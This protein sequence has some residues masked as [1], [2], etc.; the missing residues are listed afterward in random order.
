MLTAGAAVTNGCGCARNG[1][2]TQVR[3]RGPSRR[4]HTHPRLS[5]TS[6]QPS[7]TLCHRP[8]TISQTRLPGGTCLGHRPRSAPVAD[9]DPEPGLAQALRH[10][11]P[12]GPGLA[13]R[14]LGSLAGSSAVVCRDVLLES[15]VHTTHTATCVRRAVRRDLGRGRGEALE[16]SVQVVIFTSELEG[17]VTPTPQLHDEHGGGERSTRRT[18]TPERRRLTGPATPPTRTSSF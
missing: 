6:V 10:S 4:A 18:Q 17:R 7:P 16:G 8:V 9:A 11:R 2:R 12:P 15:A 13:A 1:A 3:R 5:A 14:V